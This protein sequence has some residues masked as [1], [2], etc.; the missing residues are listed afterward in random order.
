MDCAFWC[1]GEEPF[2]EA[3]CPQNTYPESQKYLGELVYDYT[4]F[5]G[6]MSHLPR[7]LKSGPIGKYSAFWTLA[8]ALKGQDHVFGCFLVVHQF[9]GKYYNIQHT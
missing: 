2:L 5:Y 6:V 7:Y 1:R 9:A 8:M 3:T 4:C